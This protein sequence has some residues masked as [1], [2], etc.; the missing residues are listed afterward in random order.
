MW[1]AAPGNIPSITSI[2]R[3]TRASPQTHKLKA[4]DLHQKRTRQNQMMRVMLINFLFTPPA[5]SSACTGS[6]ARCGSP[7]ELRFR[8]LL[9]RRKGV[10]RHSRSASWPWPC[11]RTTGRGSAATL[12]F[13]CSSSYSA[14]ETTTTR[15]AAAAAATTV[16]ATATFSVFFAKVLRFEDFKV[17]R[18]SG[19]KILRL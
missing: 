8:A 4:A 1:K 14:K 16:A 11:W 7:I 17:K 18:V 2:T 6:V 5:A 15:K 19:F 10:V 3:I 9:Q 12:G 13:I